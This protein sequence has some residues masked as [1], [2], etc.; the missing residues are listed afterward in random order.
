[1]NQNTCSFW[2]NLGNYVFNFFSGLVFSVKIAIIFWL[3]D[4]FMF[5]FFFFEENNVSLGTILDRFN[6]FSAITDS[7]SSKQKLTPAPNHSA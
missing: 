4:L 5:S 2:T 6:D 3:H 7:H 1:M